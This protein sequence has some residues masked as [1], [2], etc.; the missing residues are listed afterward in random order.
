MPL[1]YFTISFTIRAADREGAERKAKEELGLDI[2][3]SHASCSE[4]PDENQ[5]ADIDLV[6]V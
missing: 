4:I 5:E 3:E 6:T 1:Y 2:Y